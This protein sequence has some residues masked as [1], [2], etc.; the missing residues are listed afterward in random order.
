MRAPATNKEILYINAF[1][2]GTLAFLDATRQQET[3][4]A[5]RKYTELT[6]EGK[7]ELCDRYKAT[8]SMRLTAAD[9]GVS[10][11]TVSNIV[12]TEDE[13]RK[14][15]E[16]GANSND[17]RSANLK[18]ETVDRCCWLWFAKCDRSACQ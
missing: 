18:H 5:K 10:S 7:L 14:K 4:L 12:K 17:M 11:G 8:K 1:E 6:L 15:I 3:K 13:L 9:F 16:N 2:T